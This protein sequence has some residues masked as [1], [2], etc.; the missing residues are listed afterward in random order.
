M[1][2][3]IIVRRRVQ[4]DF[5]IL[6]NDVVRDP[7]LS[8]KALGLLVYVLS[9]PDDFR[10]HL[11]YLTKQKPTGRDGTRAGLKEL[12]AAGYLTIRRERRS[13]RFAQVVWEVTDSPAGGVPAGIPPRSENPNTVNPGTVFPSQEKPTLP[14]TGIQQE[15]TE[16]VPTTTQAASPAPLA[17]DHDVVVDDD[18]LVWPPALRED[19]KGSARQIL[20]DCPLAH[21]QLVLHEIAGLADRGTVRHPLGLLRKLVERARQGQFVPAAALEHRRKLESQARADQA[22]ITDEQHRQQQSTPQAREAARTRLA[23]LR[24]QLGGQYPHSNTKESP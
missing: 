24:Q 23:V 19:V 21:R 7:R 1:S 12:E 8:W 22:R 11:K 13:G 18:E 15:P 6:P 10:L 20:H 2:N 14:S 5:T 4:R 3:P 16:Q 9:L 17:H